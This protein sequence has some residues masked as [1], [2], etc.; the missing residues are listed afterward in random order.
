MLYHYSETINEK[1]ILRDWYTPFRLRIL[2][3]ESI[4]MRFI[5]YEW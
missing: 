5:P 3:D 4:A 1:N 2:S